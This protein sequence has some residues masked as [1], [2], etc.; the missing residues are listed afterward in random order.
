MQMPIKQHVE[1]VFAPTAGFTPVEQQMIAAWAEGLFL[2]LML[3]ATTSQ[4]TAA[5]IYGIER[6]RLSPENASAEAERLVRTRQ[7]SMEADAL[8]AL[9][10]IADRSFPT[11]GVVVRLIRA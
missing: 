1:V 6:E 8:L 4:I 2:S 11:R 9:Q 10:S 7:L 3:T 5:T